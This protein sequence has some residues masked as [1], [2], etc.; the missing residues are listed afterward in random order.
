MKIFVF[1]L[2]LVASSVFAEEDSIA[3]MTSKVKSVFMG[4]YK[5]YALV[6]KKEEADRYLYQFQSDISRIVI[7]GRIFLDNSSAT[8]AAEAIEA[9]IMAQPKDISISKGKA[10]CWI[11]EKT[12]ACTIVWNYSCMILQ[13]NG[14][15][16][17]S[18]EALLRLL[19]EKDVDLMSSDNL[20]P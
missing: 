13:I 3:V 10:H 19:V 8:N 12:G 2:L 17:M 4:E 9:R 20:T 5:N 6:R 7:S 11:D 16:L 18:S 15:D 14:S 1:S